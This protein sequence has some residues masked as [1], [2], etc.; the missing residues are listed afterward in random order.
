MTY[1]AI[2]TQVPL[3]GRLEHFFL[4][5]RSVYSTWPCMHT[6][7]SRMPTCG[8]KIWLGRSFKL[9]NGVM[10]QRYAA[11]DVDKL[12]EREDYSIRPHN[13]KVIRVRVPP[14]QAALCESHHV[15]PSPLTSTRNGLA[16]LN[17]KTGKAWEYKPKCEWVLERQHRSLHGGPMRSLVFMPEE[18]DAS[19]TSA[20]L[21]HSSI[22]S[23]GWTLWFEWQGLHLRNVMFSSTGPC[24]SL[25]PQ[26]PNVEYIEAWSFFVLF[27]SAR[28]LHCAWLYFFNVYGT[29]KKT[30]RFQSNFSLKLVSDLHNKW[31]SP[32]I[33][34][35]GYRT[36]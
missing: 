14:V 19:K 6:S 12:Y 8:E 25:G 28:L 16:R 15:P 11:A 10:F 32:D 36:A 34:F 20:P 29:S 4:Q 3:I 23:A 26:L 24:P 21:P 31:V 30:H 17:L 27:Y 35:H 7:Q 18:S 13:P 33:H 1:L 9:C 5:T 2:C 22:S